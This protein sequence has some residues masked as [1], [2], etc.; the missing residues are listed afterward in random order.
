MHYYNGKEK[1][2]LESGDSGN[3]V[4]RLQQDLITAGFGK[5]LE[6]YGADGDYGECTENAVKAFQKATGLVV[7]GIAGQNTLAKIKAI[8]DNLNKIKVKIAKEEEE[9]L[10]KAIVINAFADFPLAEP[11]AMRIKA[12]I[13][14]R[15]ALP[16]GKIAKNLYVV[17]G[18]QEGLKA[19]NITLLSGH[20][21]FDVARAVEDFLS[22]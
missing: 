9:M 7:D 8:I 19:D 17:G 18:T 20:D 1:G 12:P 13:Y 4:K 15:A 5:H 11:L 10:D 2:Y 16:Q 14:I 22:K 3:E 21:R 6:P